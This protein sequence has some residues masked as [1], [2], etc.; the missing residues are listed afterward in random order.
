MSKGL[1]IVQLRLQLV[2]Y[3]QQALV[4]DNQSFSYVYSISEGIV[5]VTYEHGY[6]FI[7]LYEFFVSGVKL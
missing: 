3:E 5:R 7:G 4:K 2:T 1:T 6:W